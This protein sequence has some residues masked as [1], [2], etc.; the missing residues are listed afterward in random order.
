[1]KQSVHFM[2]FCNTYSG[3]W[4]T[5]NEGVN[6]KYNPLHSLLH[7]LLIFTFTFF[8]FAE[9]APMKSRWW[10]GALVP[11]RSLISRASY[12]GPPIS[13]P[14]QTTMPRR[15][16]LAGVYQMLAPAKPPRPCR[17]SQHTT[18]PPLPAGCWSTARR[19]RTA[20]AWAWE[21][22]RGG[23]REGRPRSWTGNL[24]SSTTL[25]PPRWKVPGWRRPTGTTTSSWRPSILEA[26]Y[27][28]LVVGCT[29]IISSVLLILTTV[30]W[31]PILDMSPYLSSLVLIDRWTIF[32]LCVHVP[33]W[34]TAVSPFCA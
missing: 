5:S 8:L 31:W 17:P 7:I 9:I 11:Q 26:R 29:F 21:P 1:M 19:P 30:I 22:W 33:V 34:V 13:P 14:P 6:N 4:N 25:I 32:T 27:R 28:R 2:F 24:D 20:A 3:I 16:P 12:T 23:R 18:V 10:C 15:P